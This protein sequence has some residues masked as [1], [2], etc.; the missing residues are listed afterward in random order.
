M[1]TNFKKQGILDIKNLDNRPYYAV[2]SGENTGVY[3]DFSDC[4]QY[5]YGV[6]GSRIKKCNSEKEALDYLKHPEKFSQ[7]VEV[8]KPVKCVYSNVNTYS[9][10]YIDGSYSTK[11]NKYGYGGFIEK[12][13]RR[14]IIQGKG[15]DSKYLS[16]EA[17]AGE[18]LGVMAVISKALELGITNIVIYYDWVAIEG[19]LSDENYNGDNTLRCTY[20]KKV[21]EATAQGLNIVFEKVK[22]HSKVKGNELADRLA[23]K[24]VG[25]KLKRNVPLAVFNVRCANCK[26]HIFEDMEEDSI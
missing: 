13:S 7:R 6:K 3:K 5:V 12:G 26:S 1:V 24:A 22:A 8:E 2:L 25:S 15:N 18:I 20:I 21:R 14:Y 16:Y 17:N 23:K 10:A 9:Y 11:T 4:E 19:W